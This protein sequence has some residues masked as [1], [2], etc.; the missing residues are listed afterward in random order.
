MSTW[1]SESMESEERFL[2]GLLATRIAESRKK[3]RLSIPRNCQKCLHCN[4]RLTM[5]TF[6]RHQKLF[7]QSDGTWIKDD[8]DTTESEGIY[9]TA[10][11]RLSSREHYVFRN[12]NLLWVY[13][14][15]LTCFVTTTISCAD[16]T[17]PPT[18]PTFTAGEDLDTCQVIQDAGSD[19]EASSNDLLGKY[20]LITYCTWKHYCFC[21]VFL[22]IL[23]LVSKH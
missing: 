17:P 19:I 15:Y 13:D 23:V 9:D 16:D 22:C 11:R 6:K 2:S 20:H 21:D 8:A 5:K 4:Q 1:G 10:S 14:V 12:Y 18:L 3:P 7:C